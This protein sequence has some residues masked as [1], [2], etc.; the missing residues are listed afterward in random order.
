MKSNQLRLGIKIEGEHKPTYNYL[1]DYV[2][3]HKHLPP[4]KLFYKQIAQNHLAENKN[5]Y[6]KLIKV[7]L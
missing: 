5:Y 7:K 6:N 4:Q 2:T 1:K 3:K